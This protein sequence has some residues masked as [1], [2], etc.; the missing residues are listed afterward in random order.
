MF[1]SVCGSRV[2]FAGPGC[3]ICYF[4]NGGPGQGAAAAAR[5]KAFQAEAWAWVQR[6]KSRDE[7]E[8]RAPDEEEGARDAEEVALFSSGA[9]GSLYVPRA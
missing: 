6:E 8:T 4:K 7:E 9:R 5:L 2:T 1:C 3:S